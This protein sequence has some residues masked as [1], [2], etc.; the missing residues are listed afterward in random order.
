MDHLPSQYRYTATHEWASTAEE[1]VVKVGITSHAQAML[2]DIVYA[3]LPDV[4]KSIERGGEVMVLES[5]K[6]AADVYMPV[7]GEIVAINTLLQDQPELVNQSP[8]DQGWLFEVK[9]QDAED[10]ETL[11]SEQAYSEIKE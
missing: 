1:N 4:G 3:E 6:A 8:F 7:S 2:G 5:V 9:V 10:L 11:M